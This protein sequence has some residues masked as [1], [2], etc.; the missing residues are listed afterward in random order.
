MGAGGSII[1]QGKAKYRPKIVAPLGLSHGF[2][3]LCIFESAEKIPTQFTV[4]RATLA[5]GLPQNSLVRSPRPHLTQMV[6]LKALRSR[7]VWY[8][9]ETYNTYSIEKV[10]VVAVPGKAAKVLHVTVPLS[11]QDF[12]MSSTSFCSL[13]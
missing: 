9:H 11:P 12:S 2:F 6:R 10:Q 8:L 1:A 7:Y 4:D 3:L 5:C 13:H